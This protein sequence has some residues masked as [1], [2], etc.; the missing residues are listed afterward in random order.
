MNALQGQ[1]ENERTTN[2]WAVQLD[3]AKWCIIQL[4][5]LTRARA[6][7]IL[8]KNPFAHNLLVAGR[9]PNENCPHVARSTQTKHDA[10]EAN[11]ESTTSSMN[12]KDIPN[13]QRD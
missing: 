6:K 10:T 4:F 9:R 1:D 11:Y 8:H 12:K 7:Q 2:R 13:E 5:N 3:C